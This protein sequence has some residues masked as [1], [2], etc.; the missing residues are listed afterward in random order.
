MRGNKEHML[1]RID[2]H[3]LLLLQDKS[4]IDKGHIVLEVFSFN[5]PLVDRVG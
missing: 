3:A 4:G 5:P 1:R 2:F